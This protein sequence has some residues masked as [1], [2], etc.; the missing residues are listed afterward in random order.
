MWVGP[1]SAVF[2]VAEA[3]FEVVD[4]VEEVE[5][6]GGA[7]VVEAEVALEADEL[8]DAEADFAGEGSAGS[9]GGCGSLRV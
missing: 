3:G 6:E 4:A 5:D 9:R 8:A 2:V 1:R 7:F